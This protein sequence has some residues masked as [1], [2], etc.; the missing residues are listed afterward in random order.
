MIKSG[1]KT[2]FKSFAYLFVSLGTL[3]LAL[4]LGATLLFKGI[5]ACANQTALSLGELF[6]QVHIDGGELISYIFGY[7]EE[8]TGADP[9]EMLKVLKEGGW[10]GEAVRAFLAE[11]G[12]DV[13]QYREAIGAILSDAAG[14]IRR[15]FILFYLVVLAGVVGGYLLTKMLIRRDAAKSNIVKWLVRNALDSLLSATVVAFITWLLA[16]WSPSVLFTSVVSSLV[17]G[18]ISLFEAYVVQGKRAVPLKQIVNGKNALVLV[19]V[20]LLT[21]AISLGIAALIG[22]VFNFAVALAVGYALAILCLVVTSLNAEVYVV[23]TIKEQQGPAINGA[24]LQ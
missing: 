17:F 9:A 5:A 14:A 3:F 16:Q 15:Y 6:G 1:L 8:L 18:L 20:N 21:A 19:A 23:K 7:F 12:F 11:N 4:L 10:L 22:V 2:Y 13:A 24:A